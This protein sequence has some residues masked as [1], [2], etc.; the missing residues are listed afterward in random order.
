M[1]TPFKMPDF[2]SRPD[3][4]SKS[5]KAAYVHLRRLEVQ[6]KDIFIFAQ[7]G[8][9]RFK[10]ELLDQQP[11]AGDMVLPGDKITLTTALT[12]ICQMMPDL[13]TDHLSDYLI[14]D[15]NPRHGVKKLFAIFDSMFL[16]MI[17]R[18][19]WIKD[20]YA[21][22]YH[23]NRFI[24][25]L[26][27][28]CFIPETGINEMDFN[29]MGYIPSR[30]SR[31]LGTEGGLRVFLEAAIGL[32]VRT[33]ILNN[34]E[35]PVPG[36]SRAGL[37]AKSRLGENIFMGDTFESDKPRLEVSLRL[38]KPED[39]PR[40]IEI[41]ENKKLLEDIFRLVLPYY[42]ERYE[43][44]VEPIGEEITFVNGNSYLGF[45]TGLSPDEH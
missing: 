25:H 8:F 1:F 5:L 41:I 4:Q 14:E 32:K 21:G 28:V 37:G 35:I 45:S 44:S 7:G 36:G 30:L 6:D 42:V 38:E 15:N 27:S 33:R 19:E 24:D 18:L 29:S 16:K 12:G 26:N 22:V 10:G 13:F 43:I 20:I 17:C 34:Q 3:G 40:A 2:C 31:F 23:S 11:Q 9:N 39:V